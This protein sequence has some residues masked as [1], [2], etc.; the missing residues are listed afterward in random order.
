MLQ[1]ASG[2]DMPKFNTLFDVVDDT[3]IY[4]SKISWP[5]ERACFVGDVIEM[6]SMMGIKKVKIQ[7]SRNGVLKLTTSKTSLNIEGLEFDFGNSTLQATVEPKISFKKCVFKCS[8]VT[9]QNGNV[10]FRDCVF[11]NA[12][13]RMQFVSENG[14]PNLSSCKCRSV[15]WN[16]PVGYRLASYTAKG[17][18]GKATRNQIFKK[19]GDVVLYMIGSAS[20]AYIWPS[21]LKTDCEA[22]CEVDGFCVNVIKFR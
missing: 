7:G 8:G 10:E 9:I 18:K 19:L 15:I 20:G 4:N 3:L 6:A 22:D 2:P 21:N 14:I 12:H 11:D 17:S 13:L 16:L 5:L 1:Q